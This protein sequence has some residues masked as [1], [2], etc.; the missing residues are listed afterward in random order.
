MGTV[1][2]KVRVDRY[3]PGITNPLTAIFERIAATQRFRS[4]RPIEG[5]G[6]AYLSRWFIP[7]VRELAS[8]PGFQPDPVW[9]AR[10][11]RPRITVAQAT[12]AL[13]VLDQLGMV[14]VADDG[15]VTVSDADLVTP[16]E[17]IGLA[18]H[19]YHR[20]MLARSLDAIEG[21][22]A[23]ERHLGAVTVR[24]PAE[25]IGELKRAVAEFQ[26]RFLDLA[27][28]MTSSKGD[29]DSPRHESP[30]QRVV[31]MNVQLFPLSAA[32]AVAETE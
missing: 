14:R 29:E 24:V 7:A 32:I 25:R 30:P 2:N 31:Q 26:E 17:V 19:N 15:A 9:I 12:R 27:E 3:A 22:K 18:V 5:D 13:S 6:F 16:H 10:R 8:V 11:I 28:S 21:F 1:A 4:A 20:G 23:R